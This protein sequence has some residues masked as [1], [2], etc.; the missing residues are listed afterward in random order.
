MLTKRE[1]GRKYKWLNMDK[2]CKGGA[3][4][5]LSVGVTQS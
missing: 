2:K 3:K 1:R 5:E 4:E